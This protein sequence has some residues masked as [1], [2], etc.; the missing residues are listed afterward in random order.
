MTAA[1]DARG[2]THA[3]SCE[4]ADTPGEITAL[5]GTRG[6][7]VRMTTWWSPLLMTEA[8]CPVDCMACL[9][10]QARR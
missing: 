10:A 3:L 2:V 6:R 1:T 9:I 8:S 7:W 5:C 4:L